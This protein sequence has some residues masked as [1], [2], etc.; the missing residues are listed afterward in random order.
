MMQPKPGD[1]INIDKSTPGVIIDDRSNYNKSW[2]F[3]LINIDPGQ[4]ALVLEAYTPNAQQSARRKNQA[5]I[6]LPPG[7][8]KV[9]SELSP[10]K[11]SPY[12]SESPDVLVL[13]VTLGEHIVELVWNPD[14]C[15]IMSM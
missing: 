15:S 12:K 10:G 7:L 14:M 2:G 13:V 5:D 6:L 11:K 4:H 9:S 1:L 3:M 8:K